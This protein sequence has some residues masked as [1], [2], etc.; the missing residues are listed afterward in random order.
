[1]KEIVDHTGH[2]IKPSGYKSD[3]NIRET[4]RAIKLIKD[5]FENKLGAALNLERVSAPLFVAST[6]GMNDDLSGKERAVSFDVPCCNLEAEIVHS[7]A[8]WKRS[9]LLRYGYKHKEGIYTDMNAIRRDECL[10]NTHSIY[11]DQWDWELVI[12]KEDRNIDFLKEV[13]NKIYKVIVDVAKSIYE[14]YPSLDY[15]IPEDIVFITSQE[16][17]DLYPGMNSQAREDQIAKEHGA[18]FI[19]QIGGKL[20]SGERHDGRAP[21]YDDWS[22]NG[23]ILLWF[24]LL[25]RSIE[26]SSM[27][28]RVDEETLLRQLELSGC[29]ERKDLPFHKALLNGEL[30]YT[31]G[32]GLGQSRMCMYFLHKAHIGEVQASLWS[33][34]MI[35]EC[36]E[37][38]IHLL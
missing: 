26:I 16:L 10:D 14:K 29:L 19:M 25:N 22:L 9:A 38:N 12:D 18:V 33:E 24:P 7:L 31:I 37:A 34:E 32:G 21:D 35:E 1:M 30:P 2:L 13:V 3:L 23:D 6:S 36:A 4:V 28:I 15:I 17:E 11:V 27:G 5:T 20:K 8:K